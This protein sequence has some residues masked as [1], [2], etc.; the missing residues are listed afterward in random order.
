M[1]KSPITFRPK[2]DDEKNIA[3]LAKHMQEYSFSPVT[4]ADVI[5]FALKHLHEDLIRKENLK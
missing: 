3:D 4:T 1:K 5:R 2:E